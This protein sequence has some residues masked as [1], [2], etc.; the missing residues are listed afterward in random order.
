MQLIYKGILID[1]NEKDKTYS[2]EH[3]LSITTSL[4]YNKILELIDIIKNKKTWK[5]KKEK[6][7]FKNY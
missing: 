2:V 5:P 4:H 7:Y 3:G 1:F 6:K